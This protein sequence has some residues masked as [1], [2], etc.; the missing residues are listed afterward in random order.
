MGKA[1]SRLYVKLPRRTSETDNTNEQK[2]LPS[3]KIYPKGEISVG[4]GG[5]IQ[6]RLH[7]NI[8][9]NFEVWWKYGHEN[10]DVGDIL[11]TEDLKYAGSQS[12]VLQINNIDE[13][14]EGMYQALVKNS[15][16][17][18][19][20]SQVFVKVIGEL[21]P[22]MI[23]GEE[24]NFLRLYMLCQ[25]YGTEAVRI[26]FDNTIPPSTLEEHLDNHERDI[27]RKCKLSGS[28]IDIVFPINSPP[29]TSTQ[30]DIT[31]MYS[32]LRN[33]T[34]LAPPKYTW[35]QSID[36]IGPNDI[37]P[38]HDLERIRL[39]RNDLAHSQGSVS[40]KYTEKEFNSMWQNLDM[41]KT[42]ILSL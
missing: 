3:V 21:D 24:N 13:S 8:K 36:D 18:G 37:L 23:S 30:F 5:T 34:N 42:L 14:D 11:K 9:E 35:A 17:A 19:E 33:T 26:L 6:L 22:N 27:M 15:V 16:G 12:T 28:Q 10:A 40:L 7:L 1:F 2:V 4:V 41:S 25:K 38:V 32:L 31:I 20:S 29:V 39:F